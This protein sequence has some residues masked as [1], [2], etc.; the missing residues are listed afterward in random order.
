MADAVHSN[1]FVVGTP[2]GSFVCA[3][4][5]AQRV[6]CR[7]VGVRFCGTWRGGRNCA[8]LLVFV[9]DCKGEGGEV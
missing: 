9:G 4:A 5:L 2:V 7:R 6:D 3:L 8:N 1:S